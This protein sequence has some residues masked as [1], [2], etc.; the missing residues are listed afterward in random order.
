MEILLALIFG[1]TVGGALHFLMAGRSARGVALAPVLGALVGGL[2]WLVFTW[3]GVGL[4][5]PWIWVVSI[6]AP[7]VVVPPVLLILTRA[8][9]THDARE[10]LRL[11]IS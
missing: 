3:A 10:R 2:T 8:R 9:A 7:L 5:S 1:A 11:K 6:V 4:D